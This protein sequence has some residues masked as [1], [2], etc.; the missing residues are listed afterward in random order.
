MRTKKDDFKFGVFILKNKTMKRRILIG[1]TI[2]SIVCA[3]PVL[4]TGCIK[5]TSTMK[6]TTYVNRNA[7]NK[8]LA[9]MI[10]TVG[11]FK[12]VDDNKVNILFPYAI[13]TKDIGI[14]VSSEI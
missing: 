10:E 7:E 5:N 9:F 13:D 1:L 11:V 3:I 6:G 4:I 14:K 8:P 12:F 2:A